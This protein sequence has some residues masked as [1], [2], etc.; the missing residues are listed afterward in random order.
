MNMYFVLMH[1]CGVRP[2]AY[3]FPSVLKACDCVNGGR[4]QGQTPVP[5]G[6]QGL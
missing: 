6:T 4:V 5:R 1:H 3:M 2:D